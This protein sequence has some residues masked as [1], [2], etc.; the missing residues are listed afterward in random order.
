VESETSLKIYRIEIKEV[1]WT[2]GEGG[3]EK[4]CG[5]SKDVYENKERKKR[6]FGGSHD[7]FENKEDTPFNPT[8]LMKTICLPQM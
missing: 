4:I 3:S 1:A 7:V 6:H 8:M 5:G 2:V